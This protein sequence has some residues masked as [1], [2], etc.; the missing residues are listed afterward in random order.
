M[1]SS[2][3]RSLYLRGKSPRYLSNI[4]L[5]GARAFRASNDGPSIVQPVAVIGPP[6]HHQ[7]QRHLAKEPTNIS[8]VFSEQWFV[9]IRPRLPLANLH[10]D[11]TQQGTEI[12]SDLWHIC[13][14]LRY[15]HLLKHYK[16]GGCVIG[17]NFLPLTFP[18][19]LYLPH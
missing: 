15:L 3:P 8:P 16:K 17:V 9:W 2:T 11:K 12:Q 10:N 19:S 4:R 1:V 18:I 14:P 5:G 7:L 13:S 6:T